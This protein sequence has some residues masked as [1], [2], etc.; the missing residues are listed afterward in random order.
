MR[1]LSCTTKHN[2]K[3]ATAAV[4]RQYEPNK[5]GPNKYEPDNC[6][7]A[8]ALLPPLPHRTLVMILADSPVP[9]TAAFG[10]TG[11]RYAAA[12][13]LRPPSRFRHTNL[14]QQTHGSC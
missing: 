11:V 12:S 3:L 1:S 7:A 14:Q 4:H 10:G 5:Y 8:C 9:Y 13:P 6:A 2:T